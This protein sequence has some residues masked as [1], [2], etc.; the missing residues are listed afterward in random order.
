MFISYIS[1][2]GI[3]TSLQSFF[4]NI[5]RGNK[6]LSVWNMFK[7]RYFCGLGL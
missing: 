2:V 5:R 7:Q 1:D 6:G 3:F 4:G